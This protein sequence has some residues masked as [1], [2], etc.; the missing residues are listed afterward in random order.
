MLALANANAAVGLGTLF[1]EIAT[2]ILIVAYFTRSRYQISRLIAGFFSQRGLLIAF[3][4]AT[5]GSILTLYYSEVLGIEPCSLCWW[6]RIFLY[7]Q[8]VMLAIAL[9]LKDTRIVIYSIALSII[10]AG[11]GLY[12]HALQMLGEGSLPCPAT[13]VSCAQRFLFEFNHIT[14]PFAAFVLFTF[15]I[16][17]MLFVRQRV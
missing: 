9:W 1:L 10:G 11:F 13:T 12:Q 17:T 4:F 3:L 2:V 15:L 5:V 6:Q 14:F 16:I 8:V 7:P